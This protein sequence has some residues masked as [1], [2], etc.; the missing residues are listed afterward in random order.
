MGKVLYLRPK[1]V[2]EKVSQSQDASLNVDSSRMLRIKQ[3]LSRIN[4]LFAELKMSASRKNH[5]E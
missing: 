1:D 3:A 5:D 2:P 4:I